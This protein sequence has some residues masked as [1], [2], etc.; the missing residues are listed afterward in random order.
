MKLQTIRVK[1]FRNFTSEADG[2]FIEIALNGKSTVFYGNNGSGKST[3]LSA[4]CYAAWPFINRMNNAQGTGYRTLDKEQLHIG[5]R[6]GSNARYGT[7]IVL[8]LDGETFE[9]TKEMEKAT[10][11]RVNAVN[12][13]QQSKQTA[14]LAQFFN[15]HYLADDDT[16]AGDDCPKQNMPVFLNYGTNRLVLDVPLRIRKKH[17]FS[18]R[19]ALERALENRLD[20]R[21]F[22]E[23][24]R[25]QEDFENE[26][27]SIKRDWDYRDPALE[28]V[29][30]ASLSMLDD[31][32][33]IKVRRNPLRMV[34]IRNDKEYRV[35]QLSDGEKCTLALL[36]D[37]A[38]RV[39][40]ANPC[41]ENPMEGEGIVLIDELDLHMHPAWQRKIL[42]VLRK[43]FPNIQFL[44]TTH[45]PQILGE[46]DRSY[47]LFMLEKNATGESELHDRY[48]YG[49]DS[50]S[51]LRADMNVTVRTSE[52]EELFERFYHALDQDDYTAAETILEEMNSKLGDDPEIVKCRT[53]LD[54]SRM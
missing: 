38:R 22:F 32:E 19:T 33:E 10:S 48:L 51:I 23:W 34:V 41:R 2:G 14:D 47:N 15:E 52:A 4:V 50:D 44:I 18:K 11:G 6:S 49:K 54:F 26:Q 24:F 25:N 20:F 53:Q 31:A 12:A 1:N 40:M 9:L 36:G 21:T 42:S 13:S 17:S 28:C 45:S 35:D 39:A 43:L 7:G 46:V 37:I 8:Q 30:K 5:Q 29:R 16:V 3:L 27:K